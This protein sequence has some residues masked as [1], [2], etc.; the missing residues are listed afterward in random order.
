MDPTMADNSRRDF[1]AVTNPSL[2]RIYFMGGDAGPAGAIASNMFDEYDTATNTL[3][4]S[5][6]LPSAPQSLSTYAAAWVPR[7]NAMLVIGGATP[8][9][10][11]TAIY[12]YLAA[13]GT[14]TV[15]VKCK[16]W[17]LA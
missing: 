17:T 1:V 16:L 13:T 10:A 2:N 8:S 14:W 9:G 12:M 4:E 5:T 15:Q 3:K 6:N 7:L 11:P